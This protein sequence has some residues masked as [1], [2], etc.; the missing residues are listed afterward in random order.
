MTRNTFLT[1]EDK[2][3]VSELQQA[4]SLRDLLKQEAI[5]MIIN[6]LEKQNEKESKT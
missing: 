1:E 6:E 5:Q 2:P 4:P 3:L